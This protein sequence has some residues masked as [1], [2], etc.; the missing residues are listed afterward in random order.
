M[1]GR[2]PV[3]GRLPDGAPDGIPDPGS[4]APVGARVVGARVGG[5]LGGAM[6][7]VLEA[8]MGAITLPAGAVWLHE[9][10]PGRETIPDRDAPQ[11]VLGAHAGQHAGR[12]TH[13]AQ[14]A[15]GV[16]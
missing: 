7:G 9:A 14:A 6:P 12:D 16:E 15:T 1:E 10:Q 3:G 11:T 2:D 4:V 5:R 8:G 13:G